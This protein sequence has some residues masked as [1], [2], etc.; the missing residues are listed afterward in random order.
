[1]KILH[2]ITSLSTGGAEKLMVDLLPRLRCNGFC[3]ELAV[4]DGHITPFMEQLL[5]QGIKVHRFMPNGGNVYNPLNVWRL[6]RLIRSENYDIVHTHNTAPQLF[7]AIGSVLCSAVFCTTEHNT[8]NRRRAWKC[9]AM[10]DRWMYNRYSKVICISQ[11]AEENLRSYLGRC[12]SDISTINN[13]VDVA[14]YAGA[15]TSV[16]LE[17]IAPSS[18]K[19]M[20]VA[21][22]RWEKDQDT[23]IRALSL[24]S[25][26]FH[27]FL[28][29]DGARRPELEAL[30]ASE[31]NADRVHFMG[32]RTD[33]PEL[34]HAADYVVMSSHFE[35][36][37][38]SSVEG[39]SVGKPFLASDVDGL[40]EV[41][42]GAGVLFPHQ[43]AQ[44]FAA[45]VLA[46]ESD[47]EE[48]ARVAAACGVRAT[49]FDIATMA[50]QYSTVYKQI[51]P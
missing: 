4:F 47:P 35:G 10:V 12:K 25:E 11:K 38:L 15:A 24:L 17:K 48:Y 22:F 32:L 7:A 45:A 14:K 28:V 37:S 29:G 46:L 36:L 2:V 33:V 9:Y 6:M 42:K 19:I 13:G 18:R 34:L 51:N 30:A 40:R 3:V 8:S 20:M 44:A 5:Q 27:L 26:Q 31:G 39:M 49:Q 21:G 41:V 1:M 50:S 43:D 23:L 16:E